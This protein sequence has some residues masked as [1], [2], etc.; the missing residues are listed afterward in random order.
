[1]AAGPTVDASLLTACSSIDTAA[2]QPPNF[3]HKCIFWVLKEKAG[4]LTAHAQAIICLGTLTPLHVILPPSFRIFLQVR[5]VSRKEKKYP[6]CHCGHG[7]RYVDIQ[8][9]VYMQTH[10]YLPHKTACS[11]TV[12]SW[13]TDNKIKIKYNTA[14]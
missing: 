11:Q 2:H 1:M 3:L 6:F 7:C 12:L 5:G 13:R 8:K 10:C 14:K 9:L 4:A